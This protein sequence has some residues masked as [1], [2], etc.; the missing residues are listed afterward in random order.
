MVYYDLIIIK[1]Q[2]VADFIFITVIREVAPGQRP[3]LQ[4]L[5]FHKSFPPEP[6]SAG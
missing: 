6:S 1:K 2:N 4:F 3:S 5:S